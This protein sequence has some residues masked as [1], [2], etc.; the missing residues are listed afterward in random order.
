[1]AGRLVGREDGN[2]P[3]ER[4]HRA[5]SAATRHGHRERVHATDERPVT[6]P[7]ERGGGA[8]RAGRRDGVLNGDALV[9][10]CHIMTQNTFWRQARARRSAHSA[11]PHSIR[12]TRSSCSTAVHEAAGAVALATSG[13][14]CLFTENGYPMIATAL[15][16]GVRKGELFGLRWSDVNLDTG[17]IDVNRSYRATPKSGKVR[18]VAINPELGIV[19]REWKERCPSTKERLVF[20]VNGRMGDEGD[21]LCIEAV[22]ASAGCHEPEDKPWH[23]LRHTFASHFMMA[24][25]S[26]LTLKEL[27]G[28]A[29]IK[30]TMRYAHLAPDFMAAEIA[31]MSFARSVRMSNG[32]ERRQTE[33]RGAEILQ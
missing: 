8:R 12:N 9:H 25:G 7:Q 26:I 22:L 2:R 14:G 10:L 33:E 20:P 28:H 1:M 6:A 27:L 30:M 23:L 11:W 16:T 5:R 24:G 4:E 19:L 31:R 29:D 13:G 3:R 18:H 21:T 32:Y 15:H 17:R